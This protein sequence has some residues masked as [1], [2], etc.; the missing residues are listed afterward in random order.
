[1]ASKN[2]PERI[3]PIFKDTLRNIAKERLTKGLSKAMPKELSFAEQT[4]LLMKTSGWKIAI[5]ELRTKPKN[6]G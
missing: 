6:Y 3:D 5:E 1:M 4:R 2:R